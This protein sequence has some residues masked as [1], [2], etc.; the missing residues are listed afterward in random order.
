M[1]TI[2]RVGKNLSAVVAAGSIASFILFAAAVSFSQGAWADTENNE[3]NSNEA[4]T[5][6][7][8]GKP[9]DNN[10]GPNDRGYV[11]K[12]YHASDGR[13]IYKHPAQPSFTS[14]FDYG[15]RQLPEKVIVRN[16][17]CNCFTFDATKSYE[18]DGGRLS[19]MWDFGDGQTSDQSVVQHCYDKSGTYNVALTVKDSSGKVCD[20][21]L[22][23]TK[24]DA[25]FPAQA[26]AGPEQQ[27][28]LN[29]AVTFNG[30]G[31][32]GGPFTYNW[33]FGDGETGQG[34]TVSH[35]YKQAGQYRVLLTVDDGKKTQCSVAQASTVARI[36]QNAMVTLQ[37][38]QGT[39]VGRTVTFD[40]QGTGGKSHW[41]FGD[42]QTWDG[43][44]RASH[45]YNKAGV[46]TTSV[47][48][49][50]GRGSKCSVASSAVKI[51]VNEPPVAKISDVETCLVS[52]PVNFD[53]SKSSSA[54]GALSYS[55]NFGDG[56][57]GDGVKASHTYKKAGSY[58][59]TMTVK[60]SSGS[61]C[62]MASDSIVVAVK[63][64]P[65]AV[66]TVR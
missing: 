3:G 9:I 24:V 31:S 56:E 14:P 10:G 48:V 40:A 19:V 30:T 38:P 57:T 8:P 61:E 43:G 46:Y 6:T 1:N 59:V 17:K 55:W 58:R 32:T 62:G 65:E 33:D 60:D 28:C 39:C 34:G 52:D 66:I 51:Q 44:S 36:Y 45:T 12:S 7:H 5:D 11:D 37:G 18:L 50:D 63:N 25:S 23:S 22:A 27:A 53:A 49:D 26:N 42:G 2:Q 35:T 41:D 21:G 16:E 13:H 20:T 64:R 15:N 29:E 47:T 4:Y 54:N